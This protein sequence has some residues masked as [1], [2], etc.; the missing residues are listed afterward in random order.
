MAFGLGAALALA[1]LGLHLFPQLIP[2]ADLRRPYAGQRIETHFRI[3]DGNM[4]D[5]LPG[6]VRPP[7]SDDILASI[8]LAWDEEG[9]RLPQTSHKRY[10]VAVYGDSFTEGYNVTQPYSDGLAQA[11]GVGVYNYGVRGYGPVEVA[12]VVSETAPRQVRR[13]VV[14]GFFSGNDLGDATRLLERSPWEK[15]LRWMGWWTLN[16]S[17]PKTNSEGRYTYPMPVII[18]GS[19]YELA[20]LSY[21]LG[22]QVAPPQGFAASRNWQVLR[23][24][25]DAIEAAVQDETCLALMFIPSKEQLYYPYIYPTEQRYLRAV[26]GKMALDEANSLYVDTTPIEDSQAEAYIGWLEQQ[27]DAL[28]MELAARPR[29]L[30]VD[31]LPAFREAVARG[32]LLYYPM[33]THWNQAGHDLAAAALALALQAAHCPP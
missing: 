17:A 5:A 3:S 30:F 2:N 4:Y 24:A 18:G 32:E 29:W 33:D 15:L 10:P 11:L 8:V 25:L 12:Q 7:A 16:D 31:L 27:R 14:W 23:A 28:Q 21:Y 26:A 13:W 20:F 1:L 9:Y 22:V 19:Y 6:Q